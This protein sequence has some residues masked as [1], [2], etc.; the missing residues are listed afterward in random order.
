MTELDT[1]RNQGE[2]EIAAILA[3]LDERHKVL[4]RD[5]LRL[6]GS[7]DN[8]PLD[9]W[10]KIQ[11]DTE[12]E[13]AAVLLLLM[14]GG[15]GYTAT[16]I[17]SQ[18]GR[19][20][21]PDLGRMSLLAARQAS[22]AASTSIVSLQKRIT[23]ELEQ[24]R[25]DQ[26]LGDI[27]DLTQEG[28]D[29]A[30]EK[31]LDEAR[32]KALATD[33]TTEALTTG[34]REAAGGAG[35]T[36]AAGQR[37]TVEM[38]W[39]TERDNRVCP[40]CS[41]LH[42]TPEEVWSKVFYDGPGVAAH[43]NCVLPGT[44]L[45]PLGQIDAAMKAFYGGPVIEIHFASGSQLSVTENHLILVGNEWIAANAIKVG[46]NCIRSVTPERV[47]SAINP[48]DQQSPSCID[49]VFAS[50]LMA[51]GMKASRVPA[52]SEHFHG[53]GK[54]VDGEIDIVFPNGELLT[55][56]HVTLAKHACKRIFQ[57]GSGSPSVFSVSPVYDFSLGGDSAPTCSVCGE[58]LVSSL[59]VGHPRPLDSFG[60]ASATERDSRLSED[61]SQ[62]ES[63]DASFIRDLLEG[64]P[65]GV[66]CDQVVAIRQ[67][68]FS[69]HV[70]DLS[71]EDTHA[72][73][74]NGIVTHNCRCW[75]RAVVVVEEAKPED[76]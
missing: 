35:T 23:R 34:Q 39:Q 19:T 6:Y 59:V 50:L 11:E 62:R 44:R 24:A 26:T 25:L 53:D 57:V 76:A 63:T 32:R 49:D 36:N 58:N 74:A 10:G 75:L 21:R 41:P 66:I 43:P 17:E 71:V 56:R 28:I 5:A 14:L 2:E 72:T 29:A 69:G 61:A 16:E 31:A 37:V 48:D 54:F 55:H 9:V 27:G 42:E 33:Q 68:R 51:S 45:I 18:G 20:K 73:L 7:V 65:G 67:Y 1:I 52:S 47:A 40:R 15:A 3:S 46:D 12:E 38:R 8:I 60:L 64:L 4:L 13:A 70:Y 22:N 30:L